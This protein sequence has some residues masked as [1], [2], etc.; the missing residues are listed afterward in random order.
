MTRL[1]NSKR[2][3]RATLPLALIAVLA[4]AGTWWAADHAR[5]DG[6]AQYQT[7]KK[8]EGISTAALAGAIDP[9]F[10]EGSVG[11]TQAL[12]VMQ[13]GKI[14]AERYGTGIGLQTKLLSRSLGKTVTAA[15]VGLMVS[16][17][18]LALDQ[19]VPVAAW[20]QPGDPRGTITLRNLL[21]MASGLEHVEEG[22]PLYRSDA[23]R[24]IF[25]DGAQDMAAYAEAKPIANPPGSRFAYSTADTMILCD[26]MTRTLTDSSTPDI[27]RNAMMEFVR[28]RLMAPA[29]L[30]S[31]TP[32]FDAKGTMIGGAMMH[33]TARDY[34]RFGELLRN[35][36]RI[37]GHQLISARW[38]SF[39][40]SSS[41]ANAAYGGHVWLNREGTGN[42]LFPGRVS[43]KMFG[44]VGHHGQYLLVSPGQRLVVLRMGI[45][46]AEQRAA[47]KSAL[48]HLM[49]LFPF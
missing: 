20:D 33:M 5:A 36:G 47:L 14:V 34:A 35:H 45:S 24:M 44:M 6:V 46:T 25:T 18:R 12:I 39:M 28:G 10:D 38:V 26:L 2:R 41:P 8:G 23:V 19:P 42:P 30:P 21:Q 48:A 13:D 43:S 27:R 37:N 32:E 11:T 7:L 40:T 16:D 4:V 49:E 31:L 1:F 29:G 22:D 9:I 17:G 15:L 3:V